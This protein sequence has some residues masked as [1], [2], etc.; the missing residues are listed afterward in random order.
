MQNL[1]TDGA[2]R[3]ANGFLPKDITNW[4]HCDWVHRGRCSASS[5]LTWWCARSAYEWGTTTPPESLRIMGA[6][7]ISSI[8]W[9]SSRWGL[10]EN[11]R[12]QPTHH[13]LD[14][15]EWAY[16]PLAWLL[17]LWRLVITLNRS[18]KMSLSWLL[19]VCSLTTPSWVSLP[20]TCER[21]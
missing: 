20:L 17:C 1:P 18:R 16:T 7:L 21:L 19:I 9:H 10:R 11:G 15:E 12:F 2:E 5:P 6:L 3:P 4:Q 13:S 14:L 8:T